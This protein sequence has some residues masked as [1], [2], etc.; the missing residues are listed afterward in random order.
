MVR[1]I[2]RRWREPDA[3][4]FR[5]IGD[6][7]LAYELLLSGDGWAIGFRSHPAS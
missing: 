4:C 5:I 7:G 3:D 1:Q 2:A 6:D